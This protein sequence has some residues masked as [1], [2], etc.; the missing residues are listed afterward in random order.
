MTPSNKKILVT[1]GAGYIG[2]HTCKLLAQQGFEP[3]TFDNLSKGHSDAV[4]WGPLEVGDLLDPNR[5][6]EVLASHAPA[7]VVHFAG[8]IEVGESMAQPELY[9]RNNVVGTMNLLEMMVRHGVRHF[10][11][12][13]TCAVYGVPQA[14]PINEDHPTNPI[15]PY[16]RTKLIVE[17]MLRDIGA[18]HGISSVCLRYFN[19]AGADPDGDLGEAH[20][21]E[22]HLIPLVLDAALGRRPS[23]TIF[24]DDYD[25]PDGTCVRDY[26][27][28]EDLAEAHR[29][30]L[31]YLAGG[32]TSRAL[33]L[34]TGTGHSVREV[35]DIAAKI[36][37]RPI[38][39][40]LGERRAGDPPRLV[41]DP[42]RAKAVLGWE[43]R[44]SDLETILRHAWAWHEKRFGG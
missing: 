19:A 37:G 41:A 25:T 35:V 28:I 4:R 44:L 42:T 11:F 13:S 16:G 31:E 12:S 43:P 8:R 29:L 27:H 33:N 40:I 6:E 17:Q 14:V 26:I 18:A 23:I 15:N 3:V 32:G 34:G 10:V 36:S 1:G 5:I 9:Y 30:A 20:D 38:E 2:S 7:A 21:P 39:A 24:G 22:T